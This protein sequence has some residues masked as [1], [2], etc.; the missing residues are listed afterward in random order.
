[1]HNLRCF[2]RTKCF[3]QCLKSVFPDDSDLILRGGS[4]LHMVLRVKIK[5]YNLNVCKASFLSRSL[6]EHSTT[7][8][9]FGLI[10]LDTILAVEC[11]FF[12]KAEGGVLKMNCVTANSVLPVKLWAFLS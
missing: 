6:Q 10:V 11:S 7:C 9:R 1:V 5:L 12:S 2:I 4:Y 3:P 8:V